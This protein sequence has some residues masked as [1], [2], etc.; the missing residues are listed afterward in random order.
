MTEKKENSL[1]A[2]LVAAQGRAK[3]LTKDSKNA[4]HKYNYVNCEKMIEAARECLNPEGLG[5][6]TVAASI[7]T[8]GQGEDTEYILDSHY[9]LFHDGGRTAEFSSAFP[10]V[11]EKG[12]PFDKAY[13]AARSLSF[14]YFLR[15][16]LMFDKEDKKT[17]VDSRD[18]TKYTPRRFNKR[19]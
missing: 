10:I 14:A 3:T 5:V 17:S 7:T 15:D 16:L 2:A 12:K 13:A 6:A 18:D 11:V 1:E 9:Q 8:I 4:F 19:S